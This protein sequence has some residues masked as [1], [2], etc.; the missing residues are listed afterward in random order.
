MFFTRFFPRYIEGYIQDTSFYVSWFFLGSSRMFFLGSSKV[1][2]VR[3]V[4]SVPIMFG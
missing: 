4:G 1:N 2:R 3:E